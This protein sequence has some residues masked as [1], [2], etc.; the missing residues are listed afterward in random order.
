MIILKAIWGKDALD[1]PVVEDNGKMFDVIEHM[2]DRG[3]SRYES[4]SPDAVYE[5]V[6]DLD[7]H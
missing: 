5:T 7:T 4:Y 1:G 2:D 3:F 6:G